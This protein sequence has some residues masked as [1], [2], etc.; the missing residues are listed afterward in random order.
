MS[1][2][3]ASFHIRRES[4]VSLSVAT[5]G[6]TA[7]MGVLS[8]KLNGLNNVSREKQLERPRHQHPDLPLQSRQF[9]NINP[10]PDKP[11]EKAGEAQRSCGHEWDGQLCAR[12]LVTNYA[13][14]AERPEMKINCRLTL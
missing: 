7:A 9:R 13:E 10:S 14:G 2:N 11:G 8:S 3:H 1:P 6:C 5:T 4:A 12:G